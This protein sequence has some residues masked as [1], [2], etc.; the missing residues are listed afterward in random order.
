MS[1][2]SS[3]CID[4]GANG[5]RFGY[6]RIKHKDRNEYEHRVAFAEAHNVD[7]RSLDG[8]II[9]HSCDNARC[10]NP[11]HLVAGTQ[12][13]N[14]M[15]QVHRQRNIKL[16]RVFTKDQ[17][18]SI[19]NRYVKADPVNGI[20]AMAREFSASTATMWRIVHGT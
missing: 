14:V 11:L 16:P 18:T 20:S 3:I 7:M 10:I 1:L 6:R 2:D 5:T 9:R 12:L 8:V 17:R 4:H 15:D 13:D 19:K